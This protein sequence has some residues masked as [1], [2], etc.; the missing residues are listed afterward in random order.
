M[1]DRPPIHFRV[2]MLERSAHLEALD[3]HALLGY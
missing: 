3:T 1:K 2:Y